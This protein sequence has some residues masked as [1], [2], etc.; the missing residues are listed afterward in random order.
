MNRFLLASLLALASLLSACQF[1]SG[2]VI[3]EDGTTPGPTPT[4]P[5][6]LQQLYAQLG[7]P[8]QKITYVPGQANKFTGSKGTV[9][10]IPANAFVKNGQPLQAPLQLEF[11]EIFSRA[12]MVLSSMPTV[13]GGR[14]LESAGE[15]FLSTGQDSTINMAPGASIML[16]TRNPAN[17]SSTAGMT[18]FVG[19]G[20]SGNS[21]FD[22]SLNNDPGSSLVPSAGGNTITVSSVL[23][24]SGVSW[25][26]CDKFYT[27]PNP[28]TKI[29]ATVT[30]TDIN[31][32]TNTMVFAVFRTFNGSI[33]M[34]DFKAPGTFSA[35][36]VPVGTP[37][38]VVVIRTVGS[39]LYYGRQD[40]TV[41][42][43]VPFAPE[44]KETTSAAMVDDLNRL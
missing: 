1:D 13:S 7:A 12:D 31:P 8:V 40:G 20:G 17:L 16:Q 35:G 33:R 41:Q 3:C 25:F 36:N 18:L 38:S 11:R 21:C 19:S 4:T 32:A 26:N 34:C 37:V 39:K 23:Y 28:Q 2:T 10:S 6:S 24:N 27:D 15:V 44:L 29:T 42:A 9:I 43:G 30:G 14:L 22:W 5:A